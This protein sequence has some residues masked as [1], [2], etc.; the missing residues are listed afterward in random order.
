MGLI[1]GDTRS[2]DYSSH[3]SQELVPL[4]IILPIGVQHKHPVDVF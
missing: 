2:L 1:K 4:C 3:G